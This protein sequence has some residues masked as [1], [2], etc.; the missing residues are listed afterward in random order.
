MR[1]AQPR[2]WFVRLILLEI[3]LGPW[4]E[5]RQ[6]QGHSCHKDIASRETLLFSSPS[7]MREGVKKGHDGCCTFP[8]ERKDLHRQRTLLDMG[9]A[10]LW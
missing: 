9:E 1:E 3:S 10:A 2:P 6:N 8:H 4:D 7:R 5:S